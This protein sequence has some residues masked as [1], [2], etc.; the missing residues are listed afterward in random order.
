MRTARKGAFALCAVALTIA[1][2]MTFAVPSAAYA[3]EGWTYDPTTHTLTSISGVT[4]NNV[5]AADSA[6][7]IGD[8]RNR[9]VSALPLTC[10]AR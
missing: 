7:T 2:L 1:A 5:T 8:N 9:D 4:L 3:N 10:R 6:L